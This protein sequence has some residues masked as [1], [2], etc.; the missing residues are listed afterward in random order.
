MCAERIKGQR[1]SRGRGSPVAQT[2]SLL[3]RRMVFGRARNAPTCKNSI[4]PSHHRLFRLLP[5]RHNLVIPIPMRRPLMAARAFG[6]FPILPALRADAASVKGVPKASASRPAN[7]PIR[8]T[9][10]PV[11]LRT[12]YFHLSHTQPRIIHYTTAPGNY[13]GIDWT[14]AQPISGARAV[15]RQKGQPQQHERSAREVRSV[16]QAGSLL[17]RRL[18]VGIP[19]KFQAH[20]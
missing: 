1:F 7:P 13:P 4:E 6:L 11:A 9:R 16:A 8:R 19:Q 2:G 15:S 20:R 5:V 17:Y 3:C 10:N 18:A 14:E 12:E